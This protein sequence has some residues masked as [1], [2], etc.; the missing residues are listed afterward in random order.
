LKQ[1]END[2]DSD[3]ESVEEDAPVIRLEEL[4][5]NM[6]IEGSDEEEEKRSD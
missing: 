4:L 5:G 6:K 1:K 2:S 3:W